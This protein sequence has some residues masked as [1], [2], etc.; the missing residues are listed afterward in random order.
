MSLF[1]FFAAVLLCLCYA[2]FCVCVYACVFMCTGNVYMPVEAREQ[3]LW[4]SFLFFFFFF[5][6]NLSVRLDLA[7]RLGW[8]AT[9]PR[10]PI[11]LSFPALELQRVPPHL[12]LCVVSEP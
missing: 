3:P 2:F 10:G 5:R 4:V 12:E 7:G 6:Q 8:L 11:R 1:C 9:E